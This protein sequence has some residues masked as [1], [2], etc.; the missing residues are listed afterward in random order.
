MEGRPLGV[1]GNKCVSVSVWVRV[2][3]CECVSARTH[4]IY[5]IAPTPAPSVRHPLWPT[6][7]P[8]GRFVLA[9]TMFFLCKFRRCPFS[10]LPSVFCC[11]VYLFSPRPSQGSTT[12]LIAVAFCYLLLS[13]SP[14]DA[15]AIVTHTH[16]AYVCVCVGGQEFKI[17]TLLIKQMVV[18]GIY[19]AKSS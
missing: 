2:C 10:H 5:S 16:S 7:P 18:Y 12:H 15:P 4:L 17:C 9:E 13:I 19:V 11:V 3:E 14:F 6:K 8:R 1:R